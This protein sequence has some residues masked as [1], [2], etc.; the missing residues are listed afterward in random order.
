VTGSIRGKPCCCTLRL[1]DINYRPTNHSTYSVYSL[2]GF[3]VCMLIRGILSRYILSSS[4]FTHP[5]IVVRPS[6][7]PPFLILSPTSFSFHLYPSPPFSPTA[8]LPFIPLE[9]GPLHR[10]RESEGER[11]LSGNRIRCILSLTDGTIFTYFPE[12]RITTMSVCI[13][14]V[15]KI[16]G[17]VAA[18]SAGPSCSYD[19]VQKFW[20]MRV[21]RM[22]KVQ[23]LASRI[24]F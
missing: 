11:C 21:V 3:T 12:N 13:V 18:G 23:L 4:S 14:I 1:Q 17:P 6:F 7:L 19:H 5:Y 24:Q 2:F 10:A 9:L 22:R 20:S 8:F 16:I 15:C